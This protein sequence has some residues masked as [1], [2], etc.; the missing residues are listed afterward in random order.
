MLGALVGEI[1]READL[2]SSL[3]VPRAALERVAREVPR[4]RASFERSLALTPWRLELVGD[5]LWQVLSGAAALRVEGYAGGNPKI[6]LS[7]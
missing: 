6:R 5:P 1:A 3:L 4:D 2:P 7:S